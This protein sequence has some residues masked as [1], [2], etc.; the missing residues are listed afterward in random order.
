MFSERL[1][2]HFKNPR[3]AGTLD[4]PAVSVEVTNPACG[5]IL[6]LAAV[7]EGDA[8]VKVRFLARGCTASVAAG[9]ALTELVLGKPRRELASIDAALVE[10]ALGG[11][12][13]ASRHVAALAVDA[14]RALAK[15]AA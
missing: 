6:R 4:P 7:F 15:A 12:P 9:S 13:E 11:L 3:N 2:D 5:D 10:A 14:V 8:A 1:L